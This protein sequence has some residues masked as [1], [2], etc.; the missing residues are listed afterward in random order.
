MEEVKTVAEVAATSGTDI[1]LY[2]T[3][4]AMIVAAL[5]TM[6]PKP[7]TESGVYYY[8]YKLLNMIAMNFG[9]AANK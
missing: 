8:I 4:V 5:M 3:G 9:K 1:M 6:L 2:V 7:A